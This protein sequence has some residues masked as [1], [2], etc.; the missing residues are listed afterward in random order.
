[1]FPSQSICSFQTTPHHSTGPNPKPFV[2]SLAFPHSLFVCPFP[3]FSVVLLSNFFSCLL[4]YYP[5]QFFLSFYHLNHGRCPFRLSDFTGCLCLRLHS[6]LRRPSQYSTQALGCNKQ[7]IE[8]TGVTKHWRSGFHPKC[9]VSA[10]DQMVQY[11]H[12]LWK[13]LKSSVR[14]WNW[15]CY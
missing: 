10:C 5:W 8:T 14:L 13:R 11:D 6:G 2:C 15:V 9:S 1:M 3:Y 7:T 4:S 12:H